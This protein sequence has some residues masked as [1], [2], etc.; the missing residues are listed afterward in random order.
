MRSV[1]DLDTLIV[2]GGNRVK[3]FIVLHFQQ[4]GRHCDAL[5]DFR[6]GTMAHIDVNS[7]GLL[8]S[9]Q[10]GFRH[11]NAG[12]FHQSDHRGGG[13][14]IGFQLACAHF[15][16]SRVSLRSRDAGE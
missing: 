14:N 15:E 4:F 8:V 16:S 1:A 11:I 9:V 2:A 13:K 7:D 10:I 3:N 12:P 5:T 6:R